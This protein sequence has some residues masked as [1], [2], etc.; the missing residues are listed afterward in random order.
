MAISVQRQRG[1]G[2]RERDE[3][4]REREVENGGGEKNIKVFRVD[5]E[6]T[7]FIIFSRLRSITG[8]GVAADALKELLFAFEW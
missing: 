3:R 8:D 5:R 4:G 6:I 2:E 7:G 1:G